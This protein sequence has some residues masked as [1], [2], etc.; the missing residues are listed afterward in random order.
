MS[1]K[2]F[3]DKGILPKNWRK[4]SLEVKETFHYLWMNCDASGVW[5]FDNDLFE[6]D[7][8]FKLDLSFI[9]ALGRLA[10]VIGDK[11]LL[12]DFIKVNYTNP[13]P[14]YNPHKPCFRAIEKNGP[15]IFMGLGINIEIGEKGKSNLVQ[16]EKYFN[17]PPSL[18]QASS[19]LVD[20]DEGEDKD[21][22]VK[23]GV[24]ENF[25]SSIEIFK[26]HRDTC[27]SKYPEN[28]TRKLASDYKIFG[29]LVYTTSYHNIPYA[30]LVD[31][32][33]Q[34]VNDI[35]WRSILAQQGYDAD[36]VNYKLINFIKYLLDSQ[37]YHNEKYTSHKKFQQHFYNKEL[38]R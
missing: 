24:G 21:E 12:L 26:E 15:K 27:F 13:K 9:K 10:V 37:A 22:D 7:N 14:N 1:D 8:G 16:L 4:L 18:D 11:V 33:Y 35:E 30:D 2:R 36:V 38:K 31:I 29:P 25:Y 5:E 17:T 6:F 3:F 23:G 20:E 32:I 19:K 28:F 34:S